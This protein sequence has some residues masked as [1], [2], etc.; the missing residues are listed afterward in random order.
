MTP[1]RPR[2]ASREQRVTRQMTWLLIAGGIL[3]RHRFQEA[4]ILGAIAAAALAAMGK[5]SQTRNVARLA[6]YVK[7]LDQRALGAVKTAEQAAI[8]T[9]EK[10]VDAVEKTTEEAAQKATRRG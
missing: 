5:E 7:Q 2:K 8:G 6:A 1:Q 4:V 10:A 9:A 3:R